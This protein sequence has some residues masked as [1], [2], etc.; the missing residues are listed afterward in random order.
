[1]TVLFTVWRNPFFILAG[2][3]AVS[4]V[5]TGFIVERLLVNAYFI[6]LFGAV[7]DVEFEIGTPTISL[8]HLISMPSWVVVNF[9]APLVEISTVVEFVTKRKSLSPFLVTQ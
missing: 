9:T 2:K 7:E 6:N 8:L 3:G 1:L 4:V 5:D